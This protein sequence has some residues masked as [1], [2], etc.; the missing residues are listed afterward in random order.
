MHN[1]TYMEIIV[2]KTI[3]HI[4]HNM[5]GGIT[6]LDLINVNKNR[7]LDDKP[8]KGRTGYIF[9]TLQKAGLLHKGVLSGTGTLWYATE[10]AKVLFEAHFREAGFSTGLNKKQ[11]APPREAVFG[12]LAFGEILHMTFARHGH[13][14][15]RA[16][17][18]AKYTG[19]P[20][21]VVELLEKITYVPPV[22]PQGT[23]KV[24]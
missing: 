23:F 3:Q 2:L 6:Y 5:D 19:T 9:N 11:V 10:Y 20:H 4:H 12:I 24:E 7:T 17:E 1:L 14:L 15:E 22:P 16:K 13:A 8:I 21:M 18:L